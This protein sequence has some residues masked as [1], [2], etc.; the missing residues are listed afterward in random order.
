M[1]KTLTEALEE[2][3]GVITGHKD[4]IYRAIKKY[5]SVPSGDEKLSRAD[6]YIEKMNDKIESGSSDIKQLQQ[7][8]EQVTKE[9]DSLQTQLTQEKQRSSNLQRQYDSI[10]TMNERYETAI[11]GLRAK[12]DHTIKPDISGGGT[13]SYL[14]GVSEFLETDQGLKN[15]L[16]SDLINNWTKIIKPIFKNGEYDV[17]RE[18]GKRGVALFN[19]QKSEY[20]GFVF[21][22]YDETLYIYDPVNEEN[23]AQWGYQTEII[24]QNQN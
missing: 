3:F 23:N 7:K 17:H 22:L 12:F 14:T 24:A 21:C 18:W 8:L 2:L 10:K 6:Y 15:W 13:Y 9:R 4:N 20:L 19:P 11:N 1:A 16:Y 5:I